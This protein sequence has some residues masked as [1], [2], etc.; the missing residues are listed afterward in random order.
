MGNGDSVNN[1]FM[2]YIESGFSNGV[3][4]KMNRV[5]YRGLAMSA[6]TPLVWMHA[7]GLLFDLAA[8]ISVCPPPICMP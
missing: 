3:H 7:P 1:P 4:M 8:P 5:A 6:I 2:Y